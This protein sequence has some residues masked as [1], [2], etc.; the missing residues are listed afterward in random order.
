[1]AALERTG[2][3]ENTLLLYTSD[4]GIHHGEHRWT[5]KESPYEESIQVPL[6]LRWDAAAW[7]PPLGNPLVLNIDLAPTIAEAAGLELDADGRSLLRRLD[8]RAE[9]RRQDFLIEH[10]EG[11]NPIPTFCAVRSDRLEVRA[12][13]NR[14]G[15]ALRSRVRPGRAKTWPAG[16]PARPFLETFRERLRE[17]CRPAPPGFDGQGPTRVVIA[18]AA[19]AL[20]AL[21]ETVASRR[22]GGVP[23]RR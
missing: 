11:A 22:R 16:P 15:G 13:H 21:G 19:L 10:L 5:R 9:G 14:R 1:M 17:L 4:N 7:T 23:S 20:L 12:I 3:L 2:R 8:G 18:L 6:V